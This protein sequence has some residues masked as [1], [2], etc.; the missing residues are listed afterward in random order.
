MN[1]NESG[2]TVLKVFLIE[3]SMILSDLI[4]DKIEQIK[5]VR[6][7][8]KTDKLSGTLELLKDTMPDLIILDL[9]LKDGIGIEL[10]MDI[11]Q[12]LRSAKTIVF[13]MYS[14]MEK[15]CYRAGCDFFFDKSTD[16]DRLMS[17]LMY[18]SYMQKRN[19]ET[20]SKI[21]Q[22]AFRNF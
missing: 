5:N 3:D 8:G 2:N 16:F 1:L 17:T 20:A 22:E 9:K 4:T 10:L 21:R 18:L 13:S 11:K 15:E 6:F 12:N 19:H 14:T 7:V